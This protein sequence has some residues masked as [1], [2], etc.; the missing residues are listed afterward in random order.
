MLGCAKAAIPSHKER[1][2]EMTA[3]LDKLLDTSQMNN[4]ALNDSAIESGDTENGNTAVAELRQA[5]QKNVLQYGLPSLRDEAWKYTSLKL[6]ERRDYSQ[7]DDFDQAEIIQRAKKIVGDLPTAGMIVFAGEHCLLSLSPQWLHS[8][9]VEL[10]DA[11]AIAQTALQPDNLTQ[12]NSS[13]G[14]IWL[15]L[16]RASQGTVIDLPANL[17]LEQP[18]H[19]V[20]LNEGNG[21]ALNIRHHW[22]LGAESSLS[23]IE[24]QH[25]SGAG[26]ANIYHSI[27]L[28]ENSQLNWSTLQKTSHE[29][30]ML[31]HSH[32][33][34]HAASRCQQCVL[35]MGARLARQETRVALVE[36]GADYQYSGLLLGH[37]RQHHDQHVWVNHNAANC[38]SQQTYRSVLGDHARGV[39]NTAAKVTQGADGSV[40]QQNTASLLLSDHAEMDA[41]PEL[42]IHADEVVASHG[43]T[44][45]QLDEEAVF[46]LRSRGINDQLAR[47]M[48][49]DGF[50]STIADGIADQALHDYVQ[51]QIQQQL[52]QML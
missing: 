23:I 27:E 1:C 47:H 37:Q 18:I 16:A 14:F 51:N 31:Q 42:E 29:F 8:L 48:L 39:V 28:A 11:T 41:K 24:H 4:R 26:L 50:V 34:Q 21:Q 32:I 43:A 45:G 40:I 12:A 36:P 20:Y 5:A 3:L 30:A 7:A 52:E 10:A 44:I 2:H 9:Y 46:Y 17:K 38:S 25:Y 35:D 15:N 13:D 19:I 49:M 22:R 6:I 33:H